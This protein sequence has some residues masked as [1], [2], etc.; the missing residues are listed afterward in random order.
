MNGKTGENERAV[1]FKYSAQ[2]ELFKNKC[3]GLFTP[4]KFM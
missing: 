4:S 1:G 3:K 2:K